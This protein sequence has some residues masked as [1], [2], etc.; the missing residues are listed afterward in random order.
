MLSWTPILVP[1]LLGLFWIWRK[2][3]LFGGGLFLSVLAFSYFIA[4]YPDWDGLSSFGNRFFISLT[5]VFVIGLAAT[6]ESFARWWDRQGSDV[7]FAGVFVA[8][9]T[10]ERR[11]YFPMGNA[12]GSDARVHILDADGTQPVCRRA[13]ADYE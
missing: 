8:L 2:D 3:N 9:L 12:D 7:A 4:C 1:A 10:L 5:P 13:H 6:L 11:L